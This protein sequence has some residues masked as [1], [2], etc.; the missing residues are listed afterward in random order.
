MDFLNTSGAIDLPKIPLLILILM[1]DQLELDVN[2]NIA[3]YCLL[4]WRSASQ[5]TS[6]FKQIF[7]FYPK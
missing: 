1:N 4:Q 3:R 6:F 2:L 7:F 5:N